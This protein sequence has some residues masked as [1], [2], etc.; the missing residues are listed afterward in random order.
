MKY[1]VISDIHGIVANLP[2]IKEKSQ[3]CDKIIILGDL[4]YANFRNRL[5]P[6]YNPKY[7]KELLKLEKD[8]IICVNGNCDSEED[9]K[10]SDFPIQE[11]LIQISQT[12]LI[13]ATHG[14]LYNDKNW[15]KENSIL[16]FGHYHIPLIQKKDKCIYVNPGSISLPKGKEKA[17]Y[18]ILTEKEIFLYDIDNNIID[19]V[20][21]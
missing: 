13:Y 14:H 3:D 16:L 18:A 11:G 17:S 4:Y 15:Y 9:I 12:P 5:S 20:K 19:S 10:N 1:I 8:K 6:Y 2:I 21:I 7:V